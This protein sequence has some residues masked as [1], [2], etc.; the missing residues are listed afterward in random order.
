MTTSTTGMMTVR[1]RIE[2]SSVSTAMAVTPPTIASGS[3]PCTASRSSRTVRSASAE[4]AAS[5][6]VTCS[7]TRPSTTVGSSGTSVGNGKGSAS[8]PTGI[9]PVGEFADE[10]DDPVHAVESVSR[11]SA[12]SVSRSSSP[13]TTAGLPEP[14]GKCSPSTPVA[15][16]RWARAQHELA[17]RDP[18]GTQLQ[19]F[20]PLRRAARA[21]R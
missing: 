15:V 13:T 9:V 4:S 3:T 18:V 12:S 11:G 6:S 7:M 17:L 8:V 14:P 5:V 20:R 10:R 1:S 2:V 19:A 21:S 16:A